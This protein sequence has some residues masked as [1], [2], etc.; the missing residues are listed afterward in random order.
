M[1]QKYVQPFPS[2]HNSWPHI[3][4]HL[5][6]CSSSLRPAATLCEQVP[7]ISSTKNQLQPYQS[8]VGNLPLGLKRFFHLRS[9]FACGFDSPWSSSSKLSSP[10]IQWNMCACVVRLNACA[11]LCEV[12]S[13]SN[14]MIAY[15]QRSKNGT[16]KEIFCH[17]H[18]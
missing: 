10:S 18:H 6:C 15:N 9:H 5:G 7:R 8:T 11:V 17:E 16:T 14:I 3:V 1:T 2:K 4:Q 12:V 13:N